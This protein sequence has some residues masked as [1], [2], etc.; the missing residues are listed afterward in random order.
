MA[1]DMLQDK[2]R[3]IAWPVAEVNEPSREFEEGDKVGLNEVMVILKGSADDGQCGLGEKFSRL[4]FRLTY[5]TQT[6]SQQIKWTT[7]PQSYRN[8]NRIQ[9]T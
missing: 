6:S 5:R 8:V 3:H 4:V 2:L 9:W 1:N 7:C